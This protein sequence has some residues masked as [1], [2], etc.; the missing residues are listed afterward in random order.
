[1]GRRLQDVITSLLI[2]NLAIAFI[3][4]GAGIRLFGLSF[5]PSFR[6]AMLLLGAWLAGRL[7][8]RHRDRLHPTVLRG[9]VRLWLPELIVGALFLTGL[10]IRL[11]GIGFGDPLVLHPDEH[12]VVGVAVRML[13]SGSLAPPVPYHYPTVFHYLLLPA[14]GLLFVRG[15]SHGLWSSLNEINT[16]TFQFY[17]LA[18]AHSAV[19]GALTILLTF[20]LARRMFPGERGRWA[21]VVAAAYVTFSFIHVKESHNAVTDAA[22]TFF[23]VLAFIACVRALQQ[24]GRRSYAVAGFAVGIAC[25]TKYSA[26]PLVPVLVA[27]HCLDRAGWMDW[28]RLAIALAAVPVGFFAGYPYALLNWPPFLEHL[29]WMSGYSGARDFDP[30]ARVELIGAYAMESGFGMI[31]SLAFAAAAA[32]ALFRRRAE[33]TLVLVL[34]VFALSLLSKTAFAFYGRYLLPILPPAAIL[35][36]GLL[37]D[38]ADWLRRHAGNR[39]GVL[40][41][42]AA[43]AAVVALIWSPARE[44]FGFLGY[45]TAEDTRVQAYHYILQH[46]PAGSTIVTEDRYLKLPKDYEV[47]RWRPLHAHGIEEFAERGVDLLVFSSD[48]DEQDGGERAERR[49]ELQRRFPMQAA[50]R[51]STGSV[52]PTLQIHV[53]ASR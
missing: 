35:V 2:L 39:G 52:G 34:T 26:L 9:H 48:R 25:A 40:G 15:K 27:A 13:K 28:R 41:P 45:V 10:V 7:L 5:A 31:F 22:L 51:A 33:E 18:R 17:E 46:V 32:R 43:A 44:S 49:R 53:I 8:I 20:A 11:W 21:G 30:G 4:G 16:E 29:G 42:M 36:G 38:A 50:F 14:F 6:I 1:M 23:I 37:V 47:I 19:L 12:Q 24:G 3:A